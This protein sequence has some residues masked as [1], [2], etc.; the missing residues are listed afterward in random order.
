MDGIGRR[1]C[2]Q[3]EYLGGTPRRCQQDKL[4]LQTLH[5]PD[6]G[7]SQRGLTRS[8]RATQNHDHMLVAISHEPGKH[9]D[10]LGLFCRRRESERLQDAGFQLVLNHNGHK[11]KKN[12][13]ESVISVSFFVSLQPI[14]QLNNKLTNII[15]AIVA[16]ALL[17][18]CVAS[19]INAK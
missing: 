15:L 8:G 10:G 11:D 16:I 6:H 7:T 14:M 13:R 17:V 3:G 18:L 2:I 12:L 4:L 1:T 19:V 5:G 9:V